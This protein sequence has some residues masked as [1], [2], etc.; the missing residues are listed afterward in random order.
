MLPNH[1]SSWRPSAATNA[2]V[3][4]GVPLATVVV[5]ALNTYLLPV[6]M[7]DAIAASVGGLIVTAVSYFFPGGRK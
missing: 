7:P 6:P 4:V 3:G 2:G 1:G 5:W